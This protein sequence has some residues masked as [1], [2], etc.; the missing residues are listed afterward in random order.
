MFCG[1]QM[2][3]LLGIES[4]QKE[5]TVSDFCLG[6]S[7]RIYTELMCPASVQLYH[8]FGIFNMKATLV[9]S[10]REWHGMPELTSN[11]P[12]FISNIG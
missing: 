7:V 10:C 1:P 8:F 4:I 6:C 9:S 2:K 11:D 3:D 12:F 5:E